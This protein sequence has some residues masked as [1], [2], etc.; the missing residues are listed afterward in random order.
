ML[1]SW[2]NPVDGPDLPN[3]LTLCGSEKGVHL[4]MQHFGLE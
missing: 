1:G 2:D 3:E 4:P